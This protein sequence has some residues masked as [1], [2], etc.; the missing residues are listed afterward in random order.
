MLNLSASIL[1]MDHDSLRAGKSPLVRLY[2]SGL[3]ELI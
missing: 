2:L 3:E 1:F